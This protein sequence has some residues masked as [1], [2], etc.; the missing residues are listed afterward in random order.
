[1]T[2]HSV[3]VHPTADVS[4]EATVGA[5]TKIWHEAQVREGARIGR[6]CT[7][8][9]GAYIDKDVTVGDFCKVQNGAFV[10]HGFRLEAG[11]F[12]GPGAML[13]NDLHP[14]AINPDGSPKSDDDWEVSEGLV[15]YGAAIGG[16]AVVLPGVTVGRMALVGAGAVV[17]RNVPER[18]IV[19]GNPARLRGFACDCGRR[20]QARGAS[21]TCPHD[22]RT[23]DLAGQVEASVRP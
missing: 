11:V 12:I 19:A 17:T 22:G 20:L 1:V 7:L 16:G 8:G 5:G 10:F 13:L 14:R 21:Y 4:P 3:Y 18:G 2:E 6:Q 23:F 15:E 9:K